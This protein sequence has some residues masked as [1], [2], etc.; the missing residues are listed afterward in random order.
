MAALYIMAGINHFVN[1]RM[2]MYIMPDWVP[3]K[4]MTN[5]LVGVAE[6]LLGVLLLIPS[7]QPLAA[8]GIIALLIAVFPANIHHYQKAKE[9]GKMVMATQIR[10]PLQ[11]L[12]IWW[13]YIFT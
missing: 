1:P 7:T 6:V 10:L 2:Y 9:S 13:A 5:A 8:W 4:K 11:L 12:L 3:A